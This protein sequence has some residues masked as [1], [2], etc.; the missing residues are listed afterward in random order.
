MKAIPA[1][2]IRFK[3]IWL[4]EEEGTGAF[5]S[6]RDRVVLRGRA[7]GAIVLR[8]S[9]ETIDSEPNFTATMY[10]SRPFRGPARLLDEIGQAADAA[11][12]GPYSQSEVLR[13]LSR[14]TEVYPAFGSAVLRVFAPRLAP[15]ERSVDLLPD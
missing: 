7:N 9:R 3:E 1:A 5:N 11:Q 2:P 15:D 4:W 8:V 12:R 13:M 10:R 6:W 14:I